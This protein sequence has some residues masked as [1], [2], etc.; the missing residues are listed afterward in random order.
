MG[1][2]NKS[3]L[4]ALIS[5]CLFVSIYRINTVNKNEISW[6]VLGY[7]L[8]LPSTFIHNDPMFNDP[9]W[10]K[11]VNDERHLADTLYMVSSNDEGQPM[12]FF[13]MGSAILYL[14]FF[15]L[16]HLSASLL[17]FPTDGFS[18]PYQY[19]MVIGGIIYTIIGLIFFRKILKY[20]F[21]D[22][23]T[24]FLMFVIVFGTNYIN[25]LTIK[26]LETVNIL[27]MLSCILIWY[28]IRW[29]KEQKTKYLIYIGICFTL[30]GLIKPTEGLILLFPLLWNVKDLQT[31]KEKLKILKEN[32]K[33][34]IVTA[35]ICFLIALP[36]I[37]YWY[38][39][40]GSLIYDTYKNNGVG[41]DL[42][43][44]H[45]FQT[46]F[47][48]RKG[49]LIYTPVMVF[50][51]IGFYHLYKNNRPIFLS[52]FI[53]FIS[54]FFIISA[55][56]EWWYGAAFSIRPLI[57]L[58]P[59]LAISF[60]YFL[61]FIIQQQRVIQIF[62]SLLVL[63]FIFLNQFQWWQL[64]N[65][66]LDPYRTTKEYYWATFLKTS[67][68]EKDKE[69]LLVNRSFTGE[70][71]FDDQEKY[72]LSRTSKIAFNKDENL[73]NEGKLKFYRLGENQEFLPIFEKPY[74]DVTTKDH[75]WIKASINVRNLGTTDIDL[76]CFVFTMDRKEGAYNYYAPGIKMNSKDSNWVNYSFLYLS[77][78]I[79]S[80]KDLLKLY[81]WKRGKNRFDLKDVK[82]EFF[83]KK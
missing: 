51:L 69:L 57:M 79:R 7:Y 56:T 27:F 10:L 24:T 40:T 17:G 6:D 60:G 32:K 53:Y 72:R 44:P 80:T 38:M 42:L 48:Y 47:S 26:N 52:A 73:L 3:S 77:P 2:F 41:L 46:L 4:I 1:K 33:A 82:V 22:W 35:S 12:Y 5:I 63:F 78:E 16:G 58:Y 76:P 83:E 65:Y 45:I 66:I 59:I 14:P 21:S 61:L 25:H 19:S 62:F 39:K 15:F 49:W 37:T 29:H 9:S 55:W 81:I 54:S 30:I 67:A 28:T 8:Y 18:L 31:F 74:R 11:Q 68:S 36:Q 70:Y 23:I 64:K 20:F 50:S 13:L 43:S 34:I 71:R 75:I